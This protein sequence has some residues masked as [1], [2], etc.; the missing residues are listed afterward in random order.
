MPKT[1][2]SYVEDEVYNSLHKASAE[3][4]TRRG[5]RVSVSEFIKEAVIEKIKKINK[6]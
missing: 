6:N 3:L 4:T 2:V 5:K 1:I